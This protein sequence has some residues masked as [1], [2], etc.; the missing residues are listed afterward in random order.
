MEGDADGDGKI[1]FEE[2]V[3]VYKKLLLNEEVR[4]Q[5]SRGC[6]LKYNSTTN[7]WGI[8]GLDV[9]EAEMSRSLSL[10]R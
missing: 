3:K 1:D 6:L 7:R 8:D 4:E 9:L 2:F 10:S 5:F